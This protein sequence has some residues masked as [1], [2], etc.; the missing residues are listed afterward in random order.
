MTDDASRTAIDTLDWRRRTFELYDN[1]RAVAET[2]DPG[3]A[4]AYWVLARNQMLQTHPAS[5]ILPE[6]RGAF[7]GVPVAPYDPAWRFEVEIEPAAEPQSWDVETGTD[8]VVPFRLLGTAVLPGIGSLEVWR[9]ASYG[10]GLFIP[11]KDALAGKPGGTY[12]GGR[13]LIDT[14][15]GAW[16]GEGL[17]TPT[18]GEAGA[19][20]T[21]PEELGNAGATPTLPEE[22]GE[23]ARLEGSPTR[24]KLVLDFNFA[25]NPSCAYDPAWACPL[26]LA[27]NTLP[28]EVP[29]GERMP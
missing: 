27:G 26:A 15:K 12:G 14:V 11:V 9:L 16:L 8:G 1:V 2:D 6:Q 20:P 3:A 25:Y 10:G 23:A 13:Y 7:T 19:T 28:V 4:H 5:A 29:V 21:P 22:H 17:D 18:P 24:P